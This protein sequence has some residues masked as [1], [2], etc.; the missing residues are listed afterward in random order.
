MELKEKI[1]KIRNEYYLETLK[2]A[3]DSNDEELRSYLEKNYKECDIDKLVDTI[4]D[5][6][7]DSFG[8]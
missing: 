3:K 7:L 1:I 2:Y 4:R 8:S 5:L 6:I